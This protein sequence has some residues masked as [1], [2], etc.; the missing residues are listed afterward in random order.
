MVALKPAEVDGFVARPDPARPV[1][2][3]FG[4]DAG[5]VSER[6][7]ALIKASVD[8]PND[9]FAL[10]RLEG[11]TITAEPS[12]LV[13][14]AQTVPLFGG[15][16]A[17]WVKAGSRNIAPAVEP[18]LA[19]PA[20]ECRVVIEA[21]D[22]RRNAPLRSL[23]ERA[24]NA[25]ALPCYADN[26]K[27]RARLIDEEMRAAGLKLAPDARAL[28][29]PLL[30]GDR[31]A[32]RSEI[33]K[34]ALYA[35]GRGEVSVDDV[36]AVVSDA[37]ALALDD[38]VDVAFAGK[39]AEL[40]TQLAKARTAGTSAGSILFAAQ[41]QVAQ[42]HKWKTLI[43]ERSGF[44]LDAALPPAQFRRKPLIEAALKTWSAARLATAMAELSEATLQSRRNSDLDNTIA[45]RALLAIA[46]NGRRR[47]A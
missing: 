21:G 18:L 8:D 26:E 23:I 40:E 33:L 3:V 16:R 42:L 44:S 7:N 4:P 2:L 1:V 13:E 36:T 43:E 30:G 5:L 27:D 14:E 15:R 37:S 10:A 9:P 34:L 41:R 6:A 46:E 39:P 31:A 25:A 38:I 17:V 24:K 12:R 45:E 11:E 19:L 29:I 22:L 35:H 47:A 32:S 28:L 20:L